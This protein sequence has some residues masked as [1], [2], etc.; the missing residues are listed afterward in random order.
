[1]RRRLKR[2][3]RRGRRGATR[4]RIVDVASTKCHDNMPGANISSDG[5]STVV[6]IPAVMASANLSAVIFCASARGSQWTEAESE[7][8]RQQTEVY[9]KGYLDK[10]TVETVDG[11]N[12]RWRRIAFQ[13]HS[14]D[15]IDSVTPNTMAQYDSTHGYVR[16]MRPITSLG[17]AG[18]QA[19]YRQLF[20]G[21]VGRDYYDVFVAVCD[22]NR[23][24]ILMDRTVPIQSGNGFGVFKNFRDYFGINKKIRYNEKELGYEK[25]PESDVIAQQQNYTW[26]ATPTRYSGGDVYVVDLFSCADGGNVQSQLNFLSHGTYYWHE[27]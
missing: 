10:V 22:R 20:Q 18:L 9:A 5:A 11:G 6:G 1:M 27:K 13:C 7:Y 25:E 21:T 16:T 17:D 2:R 19:V 24:R 14:D 8:A 12:W 4:R 15:I 23:N 26:F 3:V